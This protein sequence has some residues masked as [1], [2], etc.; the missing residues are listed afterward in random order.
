MTDTT[1]DLPPL[2]GAPGEPAPAVK[3]VVWSREA[4]PLR[5]LH[6]WLKGAL[7]T[8]VI[9]EL[10]LMGLNGVM[11]W[12]FNAIENGVE[13]SEAQIT[14]LD[15]L[16]RY[17]G[18]IGGGLFLLGYLVAAIMFCRFIYRALKN[19]DLSKA[20][21]VRMGPGWAVAY[22]FIPIM[23]IWKPQQAMSQIWRG[24]H[25]PERNR[26]E[27]PQAMGWWWGLW[28]ITNWVSNISFRLALGAGAL[29]EEITDFQ[30]YKITPWLDVIT[31]ITGIASVF[32]LLPIIRQITKAQD[33]RTPP[34]LV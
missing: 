10:L 7:I 5:G 34:A 9:T 11:L 12:V 16:L 2:F 1:A 15:L 3:P 8:Y 21:G 29:G 18:M 27:P 24:S 32:F 26:F 22:N 31:S 20:R 6:G 25:D 13:F 28:L 23:N 4:K 30:T 14:I 33:D 19:L 17:A